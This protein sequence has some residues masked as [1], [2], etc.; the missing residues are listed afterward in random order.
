MHFPW[1]KVLW[2]SLAAMVVPAMAVCAGLRGN[3]AS[4]L[5]VPIHRPVV[6]DVPVRPVSFVISPSQSSLPP[7]T[8]RRNEPMTV[9]VEVIE[10]GSWKQ[11]E[12]RVTAV[13]E[14]SVS[15]VLLPAAFLL[16]RRRR[17]AR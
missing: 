14:P 4:V 17:T 15:A 16:L 9:P 5:P 6:C 1:G 8:P 2:V 3:A 11:V 12:I 7:I 10:S 13:P